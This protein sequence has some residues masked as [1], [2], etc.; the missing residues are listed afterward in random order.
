MR[1]VYVVKRFPKV[2]ETF[3]LQE[4]EELIRQGDDVTVC[5]LR[6]PHPGEPRHPGTAELGQR[7]VYVPEGWAR[8]LR[9]AGWALLV[10]VMRP[11]R[12]WPALAMCI[13]WTVR[14]RSFQHVKRFAEAAWLLGRVPRRPDH[15]HAHFAH[16]AT[17]VALV[18][19]RLTRTPFSFTGH[20]RDIFQLVPP[21]LLGAKLAEAR[22]GVAVSEHGREHMQRAAHPADRHKVLVVRNGVD[23][24][25]FAPRRADPPGDP[26]VLSVARLVSKK[27]IDS[28]VEAA[29][30]LAMRG[31]SFRLELVGDGPM[32]AE[33]EHRAKELGLDGLVA[34]RG[35]LG[36]LEVRAAYEAATVFALPCR[37]TARGDQ[38][39]LPVAIVEA[40]SV[41]VPVVTTPVAGI[42][43]VVRD[44]HTGLLVPPHD[45]VALAD[46]LER[47]L[48][49]PGLRA[50]LAIAAREVAAGFDLTRT[51]AGLRGLFAAAGESRVPA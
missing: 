9:L 12:A 19:G 34:F 1:L 14:D 35:S 32:R 2:S 48:G 5:S 36:H 24:I 45:P 11:L 49:D 46:T 47:V 8:G 10:L 27:G 29:A 30:I 21:E 4:V 41:G 28:L 20:A 51:V 40:M 23:R 38:D 7:T 43:E 3:V 22:F 6:R 44:G 39:G 13:A 37:R 26:V 31:T 50:R 42:P 25:R 18:L 16:G 15:L 17:T 33:L